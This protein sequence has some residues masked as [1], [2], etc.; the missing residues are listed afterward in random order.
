MQCIV[1]PTPRTMCT[2][3][4]AAL[5]AY[6]PAIAA[7]LRSN[8][9]AAAWCATAEAS[10]LLPLPGGPYSSTVRGSWAL[11]QGNQVGSS[12]GLLNSSFG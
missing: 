4:A 7:G 5:P 8:K 10:M 1:L 6:F 12:R 11:W 9:E 2:M 3:V